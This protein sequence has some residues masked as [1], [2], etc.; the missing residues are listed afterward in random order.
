VRIL[1][2]TRGF[3]HPG[4][5]ETY[6]LTVAEQF[7][8]L[9]HE[10]VIVT[11]EV[12]PF[13]AFAEDRGLVVR[14]SLDG[15]ERWGDA[16]IVQDS[17]LSYRLAELLPDTPQLFRAPSELHDMQLPPGLPGVV[18]DVVVCSDRVGDRIAAL[19]IRPTVHRLRHPIDTERFMPAGVPRPA[20]R[21][22]VLLGNYLRGERL[23]IVQGALEHAGVSVVQ[24]GV[25]G[26]TN[27]SP[28][29]A[30]WDADIVVAKGRA[31]LEGM[32]CGRPVFV[33]DQFGGD[34]WVTADRY[35]AMEA[36]NFA[37]LSG[38]PIAG[39]ERLIEELSHYDPQMGLVNRELVIANHG[40]RA[41]SHRLCELLEHVDPPVRSDGAPLRELARLVDMQWRTEMRAVGFEDASRRASE[42]ATRV[43]EHATRVNEHATRVADELEAVRR[44]A[45]AVEADAE[46]VRQGRDRAEDERDRLADELGRAHEELRRAGAVLDTRR[47]RGGLLVGRVAD[48]V[49]RRVPGR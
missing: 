4:G 6:V 8:R 48:A 2:A 22:A 16:A 36:D 31:A 46:A 17:I 3:A 45:S 14:S 25:L 39:R 43:S 35:P 49:R 11:D 47:V 42:H 37:G 30:I 32:A 20:P 9:G 5:S 15:L 27:L 19:S 21:R 29:R 38:P 28:E 10:V 44:H 18:C 41:H 24:V 13:S 40:A 7:E 1:I 12:G 23:E 26:E 34:G 33:F